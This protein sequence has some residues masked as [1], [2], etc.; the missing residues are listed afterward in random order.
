MKSR[1]LLILVAFVMGSLGA[2]AQ[3]LTHPTP[4]I[5]RTKD[6]KPNLK[7][8]APRAA[9]GK[10]DL[11]GLWIAEAAPI[12]ELEKMIPDHVDGAQTLGEA[13]PSRYFMNILADF[14]PEEVVMTPAAANLAKKRGATI[15][16]DLPSAHCIPLGVPISDAGPFPHK[17]VQTP[18]LILV[19]YEDLTTFRQIY[20]DGRKLPVDP[21]PAYYGYSVGRWEGDT[22]VVDVTGFRDEGWL[23][24]FGH[25]YSDAMRVTQRFRRPNFGTLEV[26]IT[27]DDSKM[28]NKP[29]SFK[30]NQRLL[31][32][33]DI[34]EAFCENEKDRPRLL[35][36]QKGG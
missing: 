17:I 27:V 14:K 6:G 23:D 10:P 29:F 33:T 8:P 20:T 9:D 5:P 13:A 19:L 26:Q 15:S 35:G 18:G 22:L 11:S 28:Y 24:A 31:P 4:G 3:W 12:K 1:A 25:P 34:L 36:S 32:D 7:A 2:S 30:V 16:S 21:E